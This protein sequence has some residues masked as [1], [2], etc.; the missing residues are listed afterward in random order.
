MMRDM[1]ARAGLPG[2]DG[3]PH[4]LNFLG[5]RIHPS[6]PEDGGV[7]AFMHHAAGREVLV[8]AVID[9]REIEEAGIFHRPA[10]DLAVLDG[11]AVIA[12]RHDPRPVHFAD[13][14]EV[15]PLAALW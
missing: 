2:Q 9:D 15:F 1:H 14:G 5:G 4:D 8:F 12:D 13:F 11:M 10:H 6:Q 7:V 3:V